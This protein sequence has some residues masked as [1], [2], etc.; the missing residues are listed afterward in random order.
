LARAEDDCYVRTFAE[1]HLAMP[2]LLRAA[3]GSYEQARRHSS[4]PLP[5]QVYIERILCACNVVPEVP[6]RTLRMT[7]VDPGF[8]LTRREKQ[9]LQLLD[10]GYGYKAISDSLCI[11]LS[12]TK[13]HVMNIYSKL[14]V[15]KRRHAVARAAEVGLL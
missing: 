9:V 2:G 12:T 5:S 6:A 7:V 8:E 14:G 1:M 11:S 4:F 3:L 13:T 15:S 10:R